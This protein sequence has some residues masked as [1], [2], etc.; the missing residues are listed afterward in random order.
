MKLY[1]GNVSYD[2]T[3]AELRA[4]LAAFEPLVDFYTKLSKSGE[5][6]APRYVAVSGIGGVDSVR[7]SIL[8]ALD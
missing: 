5:D 7:D 8:T 3:E 1:I 4:A 2:T 6:G